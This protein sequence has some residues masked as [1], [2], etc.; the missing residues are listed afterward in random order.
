MTFE[1]RRLARPVNTLREL[2]LEPHAQDSIPERHRHTHIDVHHRGVDG[3]CDELYRLRE[4]TG[5]DE[6]VQAY[7]ASQEITAE[8]LLEAMDCIEHFNLN[9]FSFVCHGATHRSVACCLL[10]KAVAYPNAKVHMTTRRTMTA[11]RDARQTGKYKP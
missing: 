9:G 6:R 4:V 5:V 8:C 3:R 10:L 11:F 1:D 2:H 7:V